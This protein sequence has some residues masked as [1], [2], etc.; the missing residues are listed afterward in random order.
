IVTVTDALQRNYPAATRVEKIARFHL[1]AGK[2]HQAHILYLGHPDL[3]N[4]KSSARFT[5][6]ITHI[7]TTAGLQRLPMVWEYWGEVAGQKGEAW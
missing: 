5:L 1:F 7:A 2:N 6:N 4:I 3:F